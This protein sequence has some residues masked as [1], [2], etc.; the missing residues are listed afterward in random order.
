MLTLVY[1]VLTKRKLWWCFLWRCFSFIFNQCHLYHIRT[2]WYKILSMGQK[3]IGWKL[4]TC[5]KKLTFFNILLRSAVVSRITWININRIKIS[6]NSIWSIGIGCEDF[7]KRKTRVDQ[8]TNENKLK[9]KADILIQ[10]QPPEVF[11]R[12]RCS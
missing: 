2:K 7:V 12:K 4:Q 8:L 6:S 1:L 11:Y 5:P 9:T 10:K 3:S